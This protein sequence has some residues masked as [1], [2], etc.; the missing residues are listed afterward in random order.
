MVCDGFQAHLTTETISQ[1]ADLLPQAPVTLYYTPVCANRR[2][3]TFT[4]IRVSAQ[5]TWAARPRPLP[6]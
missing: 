4:A 5:K 3:S 6:P 1:R 2:G